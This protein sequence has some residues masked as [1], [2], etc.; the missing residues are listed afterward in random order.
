MDEEE[1]MSFVRELSEAVWN[2]IHKWNIPEDIAQDLGD[3]IDYQIID[4]VDQAG[5]EA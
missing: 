5:L 2:V 1:V 4:I 3:S